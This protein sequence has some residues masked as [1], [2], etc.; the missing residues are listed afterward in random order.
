MKIDLT[1]KNAAIVVILLLDLLFFAVAIA[2]SLHGGELKE[3]AD[4]VWGLFTGTNG[5]L[6]LILNNEGKRSDPPPPGADA[7]PTK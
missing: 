6:F 1:G 2:L 3:L 7:N 5:G 4:K